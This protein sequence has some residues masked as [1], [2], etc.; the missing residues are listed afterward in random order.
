MHSLV[1]E[2]K[3][4]FQQF[5]QDKAGQLASSIAYSTMFALAPLLIVLIA[6]LGFIVGQENGGHGHHVVEDALLAQI[7]AHAGADAAGMV[8]GMV[9]AQFDKPR[10]SIIAEIIGW[11]AFLFAASGLFSSLQSS[12]N[13][14]WHIEQTKGGWKQML[15]DRLASFGM[16]L[17]VGFL[18]IVSFGANAAVSY[19]S[20]H[21]LQ[22]IPVVGSPTVLKIVDVILNLIVLGAIFAALFKVLPDVDI[23][24]NDVWVGGLATSI[25]FLVGETV[26]GIYISKAGIASAYGAAGSVLVALIWLY[27]SAMILLL[28]AEYTKVHAHEPKTTA[29]TVLRGSI[30]APAGIS[31]PSETDRPVQSETAPGA[32]DRV[33]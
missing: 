24:W 6:I 32:R 8:R 3:S 23:R 7:R 9:T 4:T 27:Y 17:V 5:S 19:V 22:G 1:T 2:I 18:L 15:R 21:F 31:P 25:L 28:G 13:T 26:L 20:A 33:S 12:L 29:P 10:Q 14:V 30:D 16:I 11:A